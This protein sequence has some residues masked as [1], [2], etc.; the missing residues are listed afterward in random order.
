MACPHQ[1]FKE[2]FGLTNRTIITTVSLPP[3]ESST[4]LVYQHAFTLFDLFPWLH[5]EVLVEVKTTHTF[6]SKWFPSRHSF[7][8]PYGEQRAFDRHLRFIT[9]RVLLEHNETF[10]CSTFF[11]F[12][13]LAHN[14]I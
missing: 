12:L 7:H 6:M 10:Y 2:T 3:I 11:F 1:V 13:F 14:G 5:Q 4:F 8:F 9:I